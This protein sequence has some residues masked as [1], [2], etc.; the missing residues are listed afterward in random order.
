MAGS[1]PK[2]NLTRYNRI[3]ILN[4]LG[5]SYKKLTTGI[6]EVLLSSSEKLEEWKSIIR[7]GVVCLVED[8]HKKQFTVLVINMDQG[9]I[10]WKQHIDNHLICERRRRWIFVL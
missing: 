6:V 9:A 8:L 10:V 7:P 5:N 4:L 3:L 1:K 2:M